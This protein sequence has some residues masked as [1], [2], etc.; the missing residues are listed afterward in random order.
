M[1]TKADEK[2]LEMINTITNP[3][4]ALMSGIQSAEELDL[5]QAAAGQKKPDK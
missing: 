2:F 4:L 5:F 1:N 3:G